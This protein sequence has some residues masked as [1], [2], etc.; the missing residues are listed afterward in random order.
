MLKGLKSLY[1]KMIG[2][3]QNQKPNHEQNTN[4][5][6]EMGLIDVMNKMV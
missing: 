6:S 4:E 2:I 1:G 5:Y 3:C